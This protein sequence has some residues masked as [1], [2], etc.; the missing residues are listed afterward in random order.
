MNEA[1]RFEIDPD[2]VKSRWERVSTTPKDNDLYGMRVALVTGVNPQ[3]VHGSLTYFFDKSDQLQRITF[4]GWTGDATQLVQLLTD[5]YGFSVRETH[6]GALYVSKSF[7]GVKGAL[8]LQ[9]AAVIRSATPTQQ[10]AI[11]LEMNNPNGSLSLSREFS[12]MLPR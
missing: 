2:W 8:M 7:F 11:S 12:S 9:N 1:F 10:V 3:D 4:R 5:R 6:M